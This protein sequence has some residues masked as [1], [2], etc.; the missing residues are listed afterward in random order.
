VPEPN[1]AWWKINH[2]PAYSRLMDE[3]FH[4]YPDT[5]VP[6]ADEMGTDEEWQQLERDPALF[7]EFRQAFGLHPL[8]DGKEPNQEPMVIAPLP[9]YPS[10]IVDHK[11]DALVCSRCGRTVDE[12]TRQ[13]ICF[14]CFTGDRLKD[15]FYGPKRKPIRTVEPKERPPDV[16]TSVPR[17]TR[18][19]IQS[20]EPIRETPTKAAPAR[21]ADTQNLTHSVDVGDDRLPPQRARDLV[22][23]AIQSEPERVREQPK[24]EPKTIPETIPENEQKEFPEQFGNNSETIQIPNS[25]EPDKQAPVPAGEG[26]KKKGRVGRQR[27][28]EEPGKNGE[29]PVKKVVLFRHIQGRH[30][31]G[32][33]QDMQEWYDRYYFSKPKKT[34]KAADHARHVK[35]WERGQRW[36]A[37]Y[38]GRSYQS[39]AVGHSS[40]IVAYRKRATSSY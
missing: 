6:K 34:G 19:F 30:W 16:R 27:R 2:P 12:L 8:D 37:E 1:P 35:S 9:P 13:G 21:I 4:D 40:K 36:I 28:Y 25:S 11:P 29:I 31:P 10:P 14:P 33:S 22:T 24:I 23:P 32:M 38:E 17:P 7:E 39:G 26:Y 3:V 15:F 20:K 5:A 18:P